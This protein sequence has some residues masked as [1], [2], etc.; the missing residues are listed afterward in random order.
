MI[1][2]HG[3]RS[4]G[5]GGHTRADPDGLTRRERE[6]VHLLATGRRD[7]DIAATLHIS[8][9]TV[10]HHVQSILAKFG[11]DNRVQ[12]AARVLQGQLATE[13]YPNAIPPWWNREF[14]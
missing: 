12:A 13:P 3:P 4:R 8:R 7:A 1:T 11:V 6:V 2:I 5:L 10:G 9:K 14:V